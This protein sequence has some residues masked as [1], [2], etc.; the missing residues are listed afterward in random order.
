VAGSVKVQ[1]APLAQFIVSQ[2]NQAF[3]SSMDHTLLIAAIIMAV[4]AVVVLVILPTRVRPYSEPKNVQP[5]PVNK[6]KSGKGG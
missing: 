6:A 1:S 4:A 2:A 3:T 5:P